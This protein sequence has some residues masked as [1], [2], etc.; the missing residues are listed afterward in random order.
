MAKR[1][2]PGHE[3]IAHYQAYVVGGSVHAVE[4][5][6]MPD[7]S[8]VAW[9]LP[10]GCRGLVLFHSLKSIPGSLQ[11]LLGLMEGQ[12]I[13]LPPIPPPAP[14][15]WPPISFTGFKEQVEGIAGALRVVTSLPLF[16]FDVVLD[17][18]GELVVV[19]LNYFPSLKGFPAADRAIED[20]VLLGAQH[21]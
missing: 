19:D 17:G 1:W 6:S 2:L 4:K 5:A 10:G 3:S 18:S 9:A 7:V 8:P 11:S 14:P 16:G 15:Q 20:A 21:G 13:Q 12:G